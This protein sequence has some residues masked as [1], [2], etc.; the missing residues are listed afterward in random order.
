M[1]VGSAAAAV[2]V[3]VAKKRVVMWVSLV[4]RLVLAVGLLDCSVW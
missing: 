4:G 1:A 3:V 2:V